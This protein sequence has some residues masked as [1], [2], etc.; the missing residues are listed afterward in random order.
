MS[1]RNSREALKE[2][3]SM[4]FRRLPDSLLTALVAVPVLTAC[5]SSHVLVGTPRPAISSD[6]VK[7]YVHAPAKYEDIA[8]LESSS[9]R[10]L[11]FTAQARS[12][13]VVERLKDEAAKLGA[14]GILVQSLG[15]QQVGAVDTGFANFH[16]NTAFNFESSHARFDKSGSAMA[17]YVTQE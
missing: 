7:I 12:D 16:G 5:V 6:Q 13:K 14:N 10:S 4:F 3:E 9:R 1:T 2:S 15:D 17:I 11:S 8:I